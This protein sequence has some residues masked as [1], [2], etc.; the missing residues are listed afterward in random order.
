ML[1]VITAGNYLAASASKYD[2]FII[3]VRVTKERAAH[4]HI[5]QAESTKGRCSSEFRADT[6]S[7]HQLLMISGTARRLHNV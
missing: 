6:T 2:I 7:D 1:P 4:C 3:Q 5:P